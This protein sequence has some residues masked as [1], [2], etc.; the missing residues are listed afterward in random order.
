MKR[1]YVVK[2]ACLLSCGRILPMFFFSRESFR[3]KTKPTKRSRKGLR[4]ALPRE[5]FNIAKRPGL[6]LA[7]RS[8]VTPGNDKQTTCRSFVDFPMLCPTLHLVLKDRL[9]PWLPRDVWLSEDP[10]MLSLVQHAYYRNYRSLRWR[11]PQSTHDWEPRQDQSLF[12]DR[13]LSGFW[14]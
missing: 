3:R 1:P 2:T 10:T 14:T 7:I 6:R 4:R 13:N 12:V 8:G 11:L 5:S 9:L